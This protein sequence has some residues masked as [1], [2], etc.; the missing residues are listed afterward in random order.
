[1]KSCRATISATFQSSPP[2]Y[3]TQTQLGL[4]DVWD[5]NA[6]QWSRRSLWSPLNIGNATNLLVKWINI[7][8]TPGLGP[9]VKELER[10]F[11]RTQLQAREEKHHSSRSDHSAISRYLDGAR[12][13]VQSAAS[14]PREAYRTRSL[15]TI[16]H[17]SPSTDLEWTDIVRV[18]KRKRLVGDRAREEFEKRLKHEVVDLTLDSEDD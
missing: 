13:V 5:V 9:L 2:P 7:G 1:M 10:Q 6:T 3:A 16:D 4:C 8:F 15:L 17:Q 14:R 18:D 11:D 12:R